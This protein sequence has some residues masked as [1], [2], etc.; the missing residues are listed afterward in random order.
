[1]EIGIDDTAKIIT[2][3]LSN[4]EQKDVATEAQISQLIKKYSEKKYY[5]AVMK[6]G[7]GDL[8]DSILS[9]I[10]ANRDIDK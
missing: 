2:I 7:D 6:S 8:Y 9:L 10:I 3:L 5:I 1:M 4:A